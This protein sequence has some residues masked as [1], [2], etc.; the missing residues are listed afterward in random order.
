MI[1]FVI[2]NEPAGKRLDHFVTTV[3]RIEA[4]TGNDFFSVLP[5][6][7][8]NRLEAEADFREWR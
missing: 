2:P 3:D 5:D 1:G 4:L 8:E 6:E 7:L